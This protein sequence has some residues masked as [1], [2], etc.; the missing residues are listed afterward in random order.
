VAAAAGLTLPLPGRC[1]TIHLL[2]AARSGVPVMRWLGAVVVLAGAIVPSR[3]STLGPQDVCVL[4]NKNLPV[5]KSV[6]EYYC[7]RRGVPIANL[8]PLDVVD[9]EEI[10]RVDYE[11]RILNP[12]RVALK[13]RR[14]LPRVLLTVY[15]MP[16]R[17][18][19][20]EPSEREKA[21]LATIGPQL[22]DVK[23]QVKKLTLSVRLLKADIEKDPTSPLASVLPER[24]GQLK[25]AERKAARL[26]ER[27]RL[28]TYSE[29][30][31]S[32]DSELMLMWNRDYPLSRWIINPLYW[33]VPEA[34]RRTVPP[35]VMTCR[36]DA[37][38]PD[39]AKRLVDD[40]LAAE[41]TGLT[42]KVYVDARGIKFDPKADRAGTAYGGYDESFREC[43][44]L[45]EQRAKME[46]FLEDTEELFPVG[47]CTDCALYCG[48]YALRNY[49]RC[50][51]FAPGAVAWHL[52]SLEMTSLRHPGKEWAGNLLID[53]AAATI[54]PVG[55]P[56]TIGFPKPEEFYGFLVTGEYTLV[57]SY[58]R[59]QL[60]TSWMMVLVGDPLY[61]PYAKT[62]KLKSWEVLHSPRGAAKLFGE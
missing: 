51:K 41:K 49:R 12:L 4:Y 17:V 28:L 23:A 9:A 14:P 20:K 36:L 58:A 16:L 30:I 39:V 42:G 62:P 38:Y 15:G 6:A 33:Q 55:E 60:F 59:S 45:L 27:A 25:E 35:T 56:Y 21:E 37:P 48:W 1:G 3:A 26:E 19:P 22:E 47:A 7:Q 11:A 40:A 34:A 2:P 53:G 50:C 46:V 52:A 10:S 57:E 8:V 43:A 32:V 54:G 18:G 44:R 24:E 31:A 61:N 29:S 5:S 13:D